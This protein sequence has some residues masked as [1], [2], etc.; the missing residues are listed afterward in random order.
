VK[1]RL[2]CGS[3][4]AFAVFD[5]PSSLAETPITLVWAH[6]WGH[7]HTAL[8]PLA[9]AMRG[10][11]SSVL[12]DFPG[13][14]ASPIPS[15][16]W[17]TEDYADAAAEFF[18]DIAPGRRIWVG[19]SFGCRVGIRLAARHPE[20]VDGLFLIAAAGLRRELSAA[21]RLRRMPRRLAFRLLRAVTPEGPARERLRERFGSADYRAA[22]GMRPIFVKAVSEDLSHAAAQIRCP[23]ILVTGDRDTETPPEI[24]TRFH[25]LIPGS[26]LAILRGLDHWNVLTDGRHQI[27]HRLSQFAARF[28]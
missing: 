12:I 26:E 22:G 14:G 25:R 7:D 16:V 18:A 5:L 15:E 9:D 1:P 24:A 20:L 2:V 23:T 4:A 11:A 17:G 19:H 6:G 21:E 13:F 27:A 8:L 10:L 3:G 28:T